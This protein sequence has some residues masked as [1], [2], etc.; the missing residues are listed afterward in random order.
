[1]RN[2]FNK[3]T[4]TALGVS[5]LLGIATG[6]AGAKVDGDMI[7]L[8]AA[9][10]LTGKYST[11]GKNTIQGY[12]LAAKRINELGGIKVGGKTYKLEI[13]YYDDESTSA[14]AARLDIS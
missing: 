6:P 2:L 14:R 7:I 9:V 8:G 4:L 10:S 13:K 11:N 1:M 3:R 12:E 5:A